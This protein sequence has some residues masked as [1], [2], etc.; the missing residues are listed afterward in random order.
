MKKIAYGLLAT[1]S[2]AV[3][4]YA[5]QARAAVHAAGTNVV[6]N[7][8]IYMITDDGHRR[9]YT[10]AGAYLSYG[11]NS[12][13]TVVPASAE[14]LALPEGSF[15]PPRD[16]KIVCSDR[17][18]D[19]GTCYLI[20]NGKR[21][22]FVSA[23]VFKALGFSFA[24]ALYGDVSFLEKDS[25]ITN[26][27][28]QHRAGVLIN[29]NGTIYL[30]SQGGLM[31]IPSMDVLA[32]W[33]YSVNDT[34][35][36]NASDAAIANAAVI[37]RR[38]GAKLS[39]TQNILTNYDPDVIFQ[40]YIDAYPE[41]PTVKISKPESV[42]A[43]LN[44]NQTLRTKGFT[45]IYPYMD[46]KSLAMLSQLPD[47]KEYLETSE[48]ASLF[49]TEEIYPEVSVFEGDTYALY[50]A[51]ER[52][53]YTGYSH[54][55]G[56]VFVKEQGVWKWD[57]IGTLKYYRTKAKQLNP[58]GEMVTGT[59]N[60]DLAIDEMD[61][62]P[63]A[64]VNDKDTWLALVVV[65]YGQ[66]TVHSFTITVK[67]NSTLVFTDTYRAELLP[68]QKIGLVIPVYQ[69]WSI[70]PDAPKSASTIRTDLTV[71]IQPKT[72]DANNQNNTR[73]INVN[74]KANPLY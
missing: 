47:Y 27:Q 73:Y 69:Y 42:A 43:I 23:A 18:T 38:E 49:G 72:L 21:A 29:K 66:T 57:F 34:V 25:D 1:L 59:G 22:A 16:G 8:T 71:D 46:S 5:P 15:I 31:G 6:S 3:F 74:F 19:K 12:W 58:T 63:D 32:S 67:L 2:L 44:V 52:Q 9:P 35:N 53:A 10:S 33:G 45:E 62:T 37:V 64:M 55:V 65:N 36:A 60:T 61:Y 24:K 39:P 11:F 4:G 70:A 13:Q 68:N 17:G 54:S 14:D 48:G 7:G 50:T 30:V 41:L 26:A 56:T 51:T 28:D 40:S 20:T